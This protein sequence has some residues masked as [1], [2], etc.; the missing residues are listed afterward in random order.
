MC[1]LGRL[2]RAVS[3]YIRI[4][5]GEDEDESAVLSA[6][7]DA[8]AESPG[9]PPVRMP[10]QPSRQPSEPNLG[11]SITSFVRDFTDVSALLQPPPQDAAPPPLSGSKSQSFGDLANPAD[12]DVSEILPSRRAS[13]RDA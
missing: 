4:L 1:L 7:P 9:M 10:S 12:T 11:R 13:R 5:S 2:T 3:S 8:T 6:P